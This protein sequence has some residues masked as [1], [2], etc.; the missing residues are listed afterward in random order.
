MTGYESYIIDTRSVVCPYIACN[1]GET[2]RVFV[3]L[4]N[5]AKQDKH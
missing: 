1:N 2:C 5:G 4:E 3:P